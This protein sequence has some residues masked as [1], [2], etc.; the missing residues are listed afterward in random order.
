MSVSLTTKLSC[1]PIAQQVIGGVQVIANTGRCL[2]DIVK[3]CL[4]HPMK[5]AYSIGQVHKQN[6]VFQNNYECQTKSAGEGVFSMQLT[7]PQN[8]KR[9]DE[10]MDKLKESTHIKEH[11]K[12]IGKGFITLI[13]IVGSIYAGTKWYNQT[14]LPKEKINT[15]HQLH[16]RT[17]IVRNYSTRDIPLITVE[18]SC[19]EKQD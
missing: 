3:K 9:N 16:D 15:K 19:K 12:N 7:M 4:I 13:P 6:R 1:L 5:N 17:K 8:L 2:V 14:H 11:L 18:D 10:K